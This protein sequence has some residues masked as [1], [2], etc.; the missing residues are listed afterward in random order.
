MQSSDTGDRIYDSALNEELNLKIIPSFCLPWSMESI[1]WLHPVWKAISKKQAGCLWT[2]SQISWL[3]LTSA[4]LFSFVFI[5]SVL[6]YTSQKKIGNILFHAQSGLL[7]RLIA[8][9]SPFRCIRCLLQQNKGL[10]WDIDNVSL[11]PKGGSSNTQCY[12]FL[13]ILARIYLRSHCTSE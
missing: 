7:R 2:T 6:L 4:W 1:D 13:G 11:V 3:C 8:S 5:C 9:K 10:F 12:Y